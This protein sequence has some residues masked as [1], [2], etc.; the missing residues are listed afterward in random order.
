M[1]TIIAIVLIALLTI[2]S[3]ACLL[4]MARFIKNLECVFLFLES[5]EHYLRDQGAQINRRHYTV[6][7]ILDSLV[8]LKVRLMKTPG[9][10]E[11][12]NKA[13]KEA[14]KAILGLDRED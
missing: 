9:G 10:R 6:D 7:S 13:S 8:A 2:F 12:A 3:A 5:M 4:C 1:G 11:M 14:A